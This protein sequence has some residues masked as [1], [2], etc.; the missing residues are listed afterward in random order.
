MIVKSLQDPL[1]GARPEVELLL[2]CARV[3]LS[4]DVASRLALLLEHNLDWAYLLNQ[5]ERHGLMP[6]LS[7]HVLAV[8]RDRLPGQTLE[9]LRHCFRDNAVHSLALTGE[10][11]QVLHLFHTHGIRALPYK[12]PTLAALAYANP[13]LRPCSDLDVLVHPRQVTQ[14]R[15]LLLA[16][17]YRLEVDLTALQQ[18]FYLESIGQLPLVQGKEGIRVEL[19]AAITPKAFP[20]ALGLRELW[21]RR[22][23]LV[24]MG[25]E[26]ASPATEDLLLILCVHGA[27]HLWSRL[28]WVCDVAEILRKEREIPWEP[29]RK[30]AR[31]VRGE[32]MLLV[33]LALA[34][35][36][37]VAPLP[38]DAARAIQADPVVSRLAAQVCARFFQAAE[39]RPG[40]FTGSLFYLRVREHL[41]DGLRA[42]LSLAVMPT[43]ADWRALPLSPP[44]SFLYYLVRPL[45]LLGK[46]G[47]QL[48]KRLWTAQAG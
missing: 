10:L 19:H 40:A 43:E 1:S 37:L 3:Q 30:Q 16:R 47:Q 11:V 17:G 24:V 5:A 33:G 29:T 38:R 4:P 48:W 14:A 9:Q 8:G 20:C 44:F 36:L 32:R 27:K 25:R 31:R 23:T 39:P 18:A 46:Y 15:D 45:R 26:V 2:C 34:R 28:L 21:Q 12:G 13:A 42:C 6:L 7:H 41:R 35:H 22:Q